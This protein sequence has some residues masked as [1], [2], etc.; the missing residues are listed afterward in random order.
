MHLPLFP[1]E[2]ATLVAEEYPMPLELPVFPKAWHHYEYE[3]S[4]PQ[5]P[6]ADTKSLTR[7]ILM[8]TFL[9]SFQACVFPSLLSK[10]I[11]L[12][13]EV[14][15]N[16]LREEKENREQRITTNW[17]NKLLWTWRWLLRW[18]SVSP[19]MPITLST[20]FGVASANGRTKWLGVT[21]RVNDPFKKE[22]L[23]DPWE[24]FW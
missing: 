21:I 19:F 3:D 4:K 7:L 1:L 18:Y 11:L 8:H 24:D 22:M 16:G 13:K 15:M 23:E 12:P 6:Y 2:T 14:I 9:V 5:P 20:D 17:R 10:S